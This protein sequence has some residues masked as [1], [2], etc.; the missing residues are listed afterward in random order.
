MDV[1][2][3]MCGLPAQSITVRGVRLIG[4]PFVDGR[5]GAFSL[6]AI[7]TTVENHDPGDEDRS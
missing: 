6:A 1:I 4:C 3:P 7:V 2:C 5:G